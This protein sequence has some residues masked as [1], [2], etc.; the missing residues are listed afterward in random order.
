MSNHDQPIFCGRYKH[1]RQIVG[2][3]MVGPVTLLLSFLL[4]TPF[5]A[6]AW[7]SLTEG[8]T[9]DLTLR[10]YKWLGN[11]STIDAFLTSLFMGIGSV[12]LEIFLAVPLAILLNQP[13]PLR[14]VMRAAVTLP[15]AIPTVAVAAAFLWLSNTNYGLFNQIGFATGILKNPVSLLGSQHLALLSVTV[16]HAWKG[17]PLV[18]II[19]LASLQSLPDELL[20]A[21]RVDGAGTW[22]RFRYIILPHL[23]ASIALSAVLSGIYNFSLFDITFLLTGGGPAGKTLTLPLLLYFEQFKAFDRGHA[24]VTGISIFM[25]SL[26]A[27]ILVFFLISLDRK[28]LGTKQR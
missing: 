19:I 18:F 2:I 20:E 17:L 23:K 21:A 24:A 12:M 11:P 3:M 1:Y 9:A 26:L 13:L 25:A 5:V 22:S 10:N 14:G 27:L 28:K 15:W 4:I 16:A 7:W 8:A 6:A